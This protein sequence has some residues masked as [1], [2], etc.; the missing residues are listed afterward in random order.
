MSGF[1]YSIAVPAGFDVLALDDVDNDAVRQFREVLPAGADL[2]ASGGGVLVA[3]HNILV[4]IVELPFT[5][6]DGWS[7]KVDFTFAGDSVGMRY[8]FGSTESSRD[9]PSS[10]EYVCPGADFGVVVVVSSLRRVD[11]T[12]ADAVGSSLGIYEAE[13][14]R[15]S[16]GW[17]E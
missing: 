5:M 11:P 12:L 1:R 6:R 17:R 10:F 16:Q 9:D 13:D 15:A 2:A 4:R 7:E 8:Q 3:R 14:R